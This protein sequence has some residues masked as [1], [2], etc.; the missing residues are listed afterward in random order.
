M[1]MVSMYTDKPR[2]MQEFYESQ[3][4][5]RK[6]VSDML[7]KIEKEIKNNLIESC[8][9]SMK[10][11]REENR[12][13]LNDNQDDDDNEEAEPFLVGDETHKQMPYTQEATTR[14]HFKKLAKYIRLSDYMIID[15]KLKL[16][17][18]S[19][20][21]VLK[22]VSLDLSA[23]R[24]YVVGD[25]SQQQ[26]LFD[27]NMDFEGSVINF[28]PGRYDVRDAIKNS[29]TAGVDSVCRYDLFI[30]QPEFEVYMNA[31]D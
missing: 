15:S 30:S 4:K 17:Q 27:V 16:I 1:E 7:V 14:T 2:N 31:Q 20:K 23:N 22:I 19:I 3:E 13:S 18:Y 29:I 21:N 6:T 9:N 24:K 8:D 26:P 25:K 5:Q 28:T 11:F 10:T 12:I